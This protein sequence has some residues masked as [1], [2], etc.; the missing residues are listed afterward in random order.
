MR[1]NAQPRPT[2]AARS[3]ASAGPPSAARSSATSSRYAPTA[4]RNCARA[5]S[6]WP[7]RTRSGTKKKPTALA[8]DTTTGTASGA[9]SPTRA[10][11]VTIDAGSRKP[12]KANPALLVRWAST[13]RRRSRRSADGTG[14]RSIRTPSHRCSRSTKPLS[15]V[16]DC[17]VDDTTGSSRRASARA[18]SGR[19]GT[20][21]RIKVRAPSP[22]AAPPTTPSVKLFMCGPLP[23]ASVVPRFHP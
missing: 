7:R 13:G 6:A 9:L 16:A 3:S 22:H 2:V 23:E 17:A 4:C 11:T 14:T 1:V 5:A 21:S 10:R 19:S 8:R 12:S 15:A 18:R 20:S